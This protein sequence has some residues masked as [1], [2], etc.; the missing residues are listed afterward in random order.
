MRLIGAGLPRTATL[1]QKIALETVG[2]GPCY[3]MVDILGDMR[4]VPQWI[5][6]FEGDRNWGEVFE[7]YQATVDWPAAF[8]YQE[9]VEAYPD[10]KVLL[11]VRDGESWARSMRNTIWGVFH[12]DTVMRH[13]SD[14][15]GRIDPEWNGYIE[16]MTA[17][18]EKSGLLAP[19]DGG[20]P[21]DGLVHAMERYNDEVRHSVPAERLLVWAP[22]DG[23]DPLCEFLE[24]P[25]PDAPFP[26]VNDAATFANRVIDGAMSALAGW[27]RQQAPPIAE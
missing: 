25:V 16:L 20:F 14:A 19:G 27:R 17:M 9:L 2:I 6:V 3:H 24:V 26:R 11:S 15:R 12:G 1:T 21:A 18:W 4:R 5:R 8:F 7:G 23:W 13:L 22:A 10:A